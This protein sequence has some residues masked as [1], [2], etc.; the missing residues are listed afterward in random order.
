MRVEENLLCTYLQNPL[1]TNNITS[2]NLSRNPTR[3]SSPNR[4][5]KSL[6]RTLRTVVVIITVSAAHM[7]SHVRGLRK[8]LQT[9]R[10]HFRAQRANLLALEA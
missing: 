6:E 10:D 3:A 1:G 4:N 2:A 7:Q 8:A 9:V 5:S